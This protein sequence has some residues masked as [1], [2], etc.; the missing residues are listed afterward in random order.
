M[1]QEQIDTLRRNLIQLDT[2]KYEALKVEAHNAGQD[3]YQFVV[4]WALGIPCEDVTPTQRMI[5][6]NFCFGHAYGRR[7]Q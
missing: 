6:K 5:A 2:D 1:A 7:M 4:H 3:F